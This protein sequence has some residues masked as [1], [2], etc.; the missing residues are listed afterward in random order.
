MI[1]NLAMDMD[2]EK[3]RKHGEDNKAPPNW[4]W[5]IQDLSTRMESLEKVEASNLGKLGEKI[6]RM[7]EVIGDA[8]EMY[9]NQRK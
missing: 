1:N 6:K 9:I 5:K 7:N 8:I 3:Q 2:N 4:D